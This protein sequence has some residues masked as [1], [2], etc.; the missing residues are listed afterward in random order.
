[1]FN[2]G[3]ASSSGEAKRGYRRMCTGACRPGVGVGN[4][5]PANYM[6]SAKCLRTQG[7]QGGFP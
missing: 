3:Y 7:P 2:P 5:T 6:V 4:P 1:M